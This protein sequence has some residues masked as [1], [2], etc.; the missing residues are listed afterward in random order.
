[1]CPPWCST[2]SVCFAPGLVHKHFIA[3]WQDNPTLFAA[4]LFSGHAQLLCTSSLPTVGKSPLC[5]LASASQN[6]LFHIPCTVWQ[7]QPSS[8]Y[9]LLCFYPFWWHMEYFGTLV[10]LGPWYSPGKKCFIFPDVLQNI[11]AIPQEWLHW[12]QGIA[13]L[14]Q[15][16]CC[17]MEEPPQLCRSMAGAGAGFWGPASSAPSTTAPSGASGAMLM[18]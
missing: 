18:G 2:D 14:V 10:T 15:S 11:S 16:L 13:A 17:P 7:L 1:M 3:L 9:R 8:I 5:C 6:L 4:R 12:H